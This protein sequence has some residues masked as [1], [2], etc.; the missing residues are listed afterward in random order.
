[1]NTAYNWLVQSSV[2]PNETS[3][4]VKGTLLGFS[5]Y[6]LLIANVLHVS[7]NIGQYTNAVDT[8][9]TLLGLA[10]T[11]YHSAAAL[12]GFGRKIYTTVKGTNLVLNPT[13]NVPA[14]TPVDIANTN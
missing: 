2:D 6:A 9:T 10:L 13:A 3:L 14:A 5:S 12:Y 8:I 4:A 11:V 1:M 7:V